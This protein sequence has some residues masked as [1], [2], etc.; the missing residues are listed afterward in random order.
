[1]TENDDYPPEV[2]KKKRLAVWNIILKNYCFNAG[3]RF[4]HASGM[5]YSKGAIEQLEAAGVKVFVVADAKTLMKLTQQLN[6]LVVQQENLK[7]LK[8][9]CKYEGKS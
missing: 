8:N 6:S 2:T 3:Y 1:M 9:C 5:G 7:R 4:A